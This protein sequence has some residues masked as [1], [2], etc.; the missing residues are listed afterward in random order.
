MMKIRSLTGFGKVV[1]SFFS[2]SLM[3]GIDLIL[4]LITMPYLMRIIGIEK[5]G[6]LSFVA[7]T[8]AYFSIIINYGFTLTATKEVAIHSQN[9]RELQQIFNKVTT[10]K[11]YLA[12]FSFLL[13]LIIVL[14]FSDFRAHYGLYGIVFCGIFFQSFLPIWFFQGLQ[15]LKR[16][17]LQN[18]LIKIIFTAL[19]FVFVKK[20]SDYWKVPTFN[21]AAFFFC[22]VLAYYYLFTHYRLRFLWSEFQDVKYQ[23]KEGLYVFLS[24]VKISFFSSFNV[25]MLGLLVGNVAVG[26]FT[27]ADKIVRA[28]AVIQIPITASLYPHFSQLLR[29]DKYMAYRQ[30][31]KIGYG[32]IAFYI[33]ILLLTFVFSHLIAEVVFGVGADEI[34]LLIRIMV[35]LPLLII[36][37]N[38]AGKQMLLNM[39]KDKWFFNILLSNAVLNV[40]MVIP[41][42]KIWGFEGTSYSVLISEIYLCA[43]M[44]MGFLKVKKIY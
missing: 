4:P 31:N 26:Y 9:P 16:I 1:E 6:L 30:I 32:A 18:G 24:Q 19:I 29:T 39:G 34:S 23:L 7:A 38:L 15:N 17:T 41:L 13:L 11:F 2:L 27:A 37:N 10:S 33:P 36:L 42:T 14:A 22:A 3:Y 20:E 25:L 28:L 12:L 35:P 5:V 40:C 43:A 8:N 21:T 44:Y